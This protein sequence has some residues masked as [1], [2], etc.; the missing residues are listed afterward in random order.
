MLASYYNGA[1]ISCKSKCEKMKPQRSLTSQPIFNFYF[2][3]LNN[4]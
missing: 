4:N 1:F 3:F 2:Y